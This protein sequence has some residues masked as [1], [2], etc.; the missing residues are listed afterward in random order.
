MFARINKIQNVGKFEDSCG[1][2]NIKLNKVN[3][4]YANNTYGKSTLCDIFRS[5]KEN[6][7]D[8]IRN[9]RTIPNHGDPIIQ[10][11][12][13]PDSGNKQ[14]NAKFDS[15][16]SVDAAIAPLLPNIHIFDTL[17][18]EKNVFVGSQIDRENHEN[19]TDFVL[20]EDGVH[21]AGEIEKNAKIIAE[22][23]RSLGNL[24]K[25]IKMPSNYTLNKFIELTPKLKKEEL[26]AKIQETKQ[27]ISTDEKTTQQKEKVLG[28]PEPD[29]EK[30][31]DIQSIEKLC[32]DIKDSFAQTFKL[33]S[34]NILEEHLKTCFSDADKGKKWLQEGLTIS[35]KNGQC[36]F[37]GQS[38][39]PVQSLVDIYN[40][41]FDIQFSDYVDK[42][43]VSLTDG[44]G[45][46]KKLQGQFAGN[47]ILLNINRYK[48]FSE[49]VLDKEK[50]QR[51]AM[52]I[53]EL[54][55][56]IGNIGV[57]LNTI[58]PME[59]EKTQQFIN[60]KLKYDK[61]TNSCTNMMHQR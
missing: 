9:R 31:A 16:W 32:Q 48:A 26:E 23:K 14:F 1:T 15:V 37:C 40:K 4:I 42:I 47:N 22:Q 17:F 43:T 2:G 58:I 39:A 57:S 59:I 27:L 34:D 21:I 53:E 49:Y 44:Y 28:L 29:R 8:I 54:L 11:S 35:V 36:P 25:S 46:F 38:L 10:L 6:D 56:K 30:C 12:M 61:I 51:N 3:I 18:V 13:I 55:R 7:A 45:R 20:G 19:F 5:L 60:T 52:E 41:V 33:E 50:F 24:S